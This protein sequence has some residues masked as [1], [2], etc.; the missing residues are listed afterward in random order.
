MLVRGGEIPVAVNKSRV[1]IVASE[2]AVLNSR[3][4]DVTIIFRPPCKLVSACDYRPKGLLASI[5]DAVLFG[6]GI[7]GIY[8]LPVDSGSHQ[9]L[10]AGHRYC[11][12]LINP[13]K[14][15]SLTAVTVVQSIY[16]YINY[17]FLPSLFS[18]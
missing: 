13:S 12:C 15:Q 11:C 7:D 10:I 1:G 9:N 14:G 5:G 8:I 16:I 4:P 6:S 3:T 17:H 2:D 18:P